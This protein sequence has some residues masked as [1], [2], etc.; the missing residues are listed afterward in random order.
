[1]T[2][3]NIEFPLAPDLCYLNHAAVSPWPKRA[4]DAVHA[5]ATE[6][7]RLGATHYLD[8]LEVESC[9]RN[10]LAKLLNAPSVDDIA[11]LKSTSEALSVV[12]YGL[13]W[14]PGDNV[15]IPE[16]EFPSNRIVWES[17]VDNFGI[18]LKK[19]NHQGECSAEDLISQCDKHTKLISTSSVQ[20]ANGYQI[21]LEKLGDFC[22]KNNILFCVDAIQSI[23]AVKTD[24]QLWKA[25]FVMADGHKWMM[26]PEG[27]AVFYSTQKSRELL[28]LK[29]FGW[30]MVA[31][32]GN[33]DTDEWNISPSSTRFECGSPN[34]LG[35]H[36]LNASLSLILEVGIDSIE[37]QLSEKISYLRQQL[38]QIPE[39]QI[40]TKEQSSSGIITFR[41]KDLTDHSTLH[42]S[43]MDKGVICAYRGGGIRFSPH[44]YTPVKVIDRAITTVKS[45]I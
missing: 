45:L 13:D 8:W 23:G 32:P 31:N 18:E 2:E 15:V 5:F 25:D 17:L 37:Q 1:M 7:T 42:K 43:L 30:R 10:R 9:L 24:V 35:I 12:A 33:Y 22:Q 27:L 40:L 19:V 21:D 44:F 29:Q 6:N 41:V 28:S 16:H 39:I 26:G 4:L 36:T 11:L 34:M 3:L 20:Y 14:K 38:S